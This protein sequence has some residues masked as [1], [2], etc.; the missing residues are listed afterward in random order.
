MLRALRYT[1]CFVFLR[2]TG[3][4]FAHSLQPRSVK[5]SMTIEQAE[6]IPC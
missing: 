6:V 2:K 1:V 5:T 3:L 4:A